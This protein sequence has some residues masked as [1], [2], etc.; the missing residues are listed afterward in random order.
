MKKWSSKSSDSEDGT[1]T[2]SKYGEHQE[3]ENTNLEPEGNSDVS[4]YSEESASPEI[5]F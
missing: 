1:A 4:T 5:L 2:V 3:S